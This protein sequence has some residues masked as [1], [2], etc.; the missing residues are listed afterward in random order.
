MVELGFFDGTETA[1]SSN[2]AKISIIKWSQNLIKVNKSSVSCLPKDLKKA[3]EAVN[4]TILGL[5][6]TSLL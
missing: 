2:V 5:P 3:C 1:Y 4:F 6:K